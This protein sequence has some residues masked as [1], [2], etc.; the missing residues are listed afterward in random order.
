MSQQFQILI[1][2]QIMAHCQCGIICFSVGLWNCSDNKVLFVFLLEF[3]TVPTV[4]HYIFSIGL[5]NCFESVAQSPIE[6]EI[7][8]YCRTFPKSN[9]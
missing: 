6:K 5:W 2:K 1:E 3:G 8:P 9:R 7:M 4:W